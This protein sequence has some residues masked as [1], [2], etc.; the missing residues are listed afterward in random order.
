MRLTERDRLVLGRSFTVLVWLGVLCWA[1]HYSFWLGAAFSFY[2][3][4]ER[5]AVRKFWG[6]EGLIGGKW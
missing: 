5:T 3:H 6:P 1:L 2:V 4:F